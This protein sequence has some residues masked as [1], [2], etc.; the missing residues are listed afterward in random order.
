MRPA[1]KILGRDGNIFNLV[2]ISVAAL[3]KV[4]LQEQSKE[5]IKRV[6]NA[7]N[8]DEALCIIMEYV[9]PI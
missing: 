4:D 7:R 3:N 9:R 2:N 5:M 1:A 8:Y 6:F